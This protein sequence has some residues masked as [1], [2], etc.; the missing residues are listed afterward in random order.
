MISVRE[1]GQKVFTIEMDRLDPDFVNEL[2]NL[3]KEYGEELQ[4]MNGVHNTNL[5]FSEFIDA[6][7]DAAVP[8]DVSPDANANSSS[9]DVCTL[10]RDM[11]KPHTALLSNNKIFYEMKKFYGKKDARSWLRADFSGA[12]Y[13]HDRSSTSFYP[14]CFAYDLDALVERGLFFIGR[15]GAG[16]AKHLTTFND[17][18]L[19]FISWNCNRTSGAK[20]SPWLLCTA[21]YSK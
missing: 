1:D 11:I 3:S 18:V 15:Y 4:L 8:A 13:M 16:P 6:F 20:L 19:E 14:Y 10:M 2:D 17:H 21:M 7:I 5:N 9:K 12:L